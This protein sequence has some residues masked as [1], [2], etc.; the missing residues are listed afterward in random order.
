MFT[1][2]ERNRLYYGD[3]ETSAS[4]RTPL[5]A[6]P[7]SLVYE[8]GDLRYIRYGDQELIRRIYMTV[9]G[10]DWSTPTP[11]LTEVQRE[12]GPDSFRIVYEAH[13]A[14]PEKGIDF[15]SRHTL[16]GT[17]DGTL[18]YAFDGEAL[19]DFRRNRL[20]ICVL[21]PPTLA[22][23]ACTV[24]HSEG[25][26]ETG[27]FPTTI[28]PHQ[29]FFDI[30]G[31]TQEIEPGTSY[32]VAFA[33][34]VFEMEDQRNWLDASFKTY[35]TPQERPKP[36]EQASGSHV[37][38]SVT[39]TLSGGAVEAAQSEPPLTV[40]VG[41]AVFVKY[42]GVG[43]V[44]PPDGT[45][46][47]ADAA[48]AVAGIRIDHLRVTVDAASND[49][50]LSLAEAAR[51]AKRM[52]IDTLLVAV[53]NADKLT[54]APGVESATVAAYLAVDPSPETLTH[55]RGL[56]GSATVG[57]AY[58]GEFVNL[59]R[60]RPEPGTAQIIAFPDAPQVHATDTSSIMETPPT[61]QAQLETA[62]EF[63]PGTPLV[64]GPLTFYRPK[65]GA[66]VRQTG[67][68]GAAWYL[69]AIA[70]GALGGASRITLCN[71]IGDEGIVADDGT[72]YPLYALLGALGVATGGQVQSVSTGDPLKVAALAI[73]SDGGSYQDVFVANLTRDAQSVTVSGLVG[74]DTR[75]R[76]LDE[77]SSPR[78]GE[79][80]PQT[81]TDGTLTLS[82]LPF[83]IAQIIAGRAVG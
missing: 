62:Q 19:S 39:L 22:G 66:D 79:A 5:R 42:P 25:G 58:S 47:G 31:I 11:V 54:Q 37:A 30:A 55:L 63:A 50:S 76:T 56:L 14:L 33:G 48:R 36:V 60:N 20:G 80:T 23:T 15:T 68:M 17:S 73:S 67:L 83:G 81:A 32:H 4:E 69:G 3:A 27:H 24:T 77:T 12:I 71:A 78:F 51:Q 82:L 35:S 40:E 46:P 72:A 1:P 9:R 49:V 34:E 16:T 6:G 75:V 53:R 57:A 18:T 74:D 28:S 70:Y 8:N 45:K 59:N 44:L 64:A 7:L 38:Q 29:P 26:Q 43:L 10:D 2:S 41:E 52:D 61:L 65:R 21:H 13:A